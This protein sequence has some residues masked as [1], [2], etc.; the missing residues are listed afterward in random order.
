MGDKLEALESD[1]EE[2]MDDDD[3]DELELEGAAAFVDVEGATGFLN[4]VT[5]AKC[6]QY[7]KVR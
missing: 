3:D 1:A 4:D 2:E 5:A 7:R 6:N